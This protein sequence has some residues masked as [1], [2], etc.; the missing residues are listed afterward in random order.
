V[1]DDPI[2]A[3]LETLGRSLRGRPNR[4]RVLAETEDHL[5]SSA[6]SL[7]EQGLAPDA[8]AR[9]AVRR[10][11]SAE[12]VGRAAGG[13]VAAIIVLVLGWT[14]T[15]FL[16]AAAGAVRGDGQDGAAAGAPILLG[17]GALAALIVTPLAA[18]AV[19]SWSNALHSADAV[20]RR[21][22]ALVAALAAAALAELAVHVAKHQSGG[23][24]STREG[25][26][27]ACLALAALIL[28]ATVIYLELHA[29]AEQ[30]RNA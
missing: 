7:E 30:R 13:R 21:V 5:R 27:L 10:M 20:W 6:E 8:A 17:L 16:F 23:S 14:G 29:R 25:R 3:Y 15:A 11:G 1:T 12:D 9:E 19:W 18:L 4:D 22:T 26:A 24:R 2:A 28:C